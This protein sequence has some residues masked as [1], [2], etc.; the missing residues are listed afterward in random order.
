MDYYF[1]QQQHLTEFQKCNEI[2][3]RT[4]TD[5]KIIILSQDLCY[6]IKP[7]QYLLVFS[8]SACNMEPLT[9]K[10]KTKLKILARFEARAES[11]SM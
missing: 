1:Q 11:L 3:Y 10:H 2:I 9:W 4:F 7:H 5:K 6:S 8:V